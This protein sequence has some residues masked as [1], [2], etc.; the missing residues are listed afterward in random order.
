MFA[1]S[2]GGGS[3]QWGYTVVV[4]S[5]GASGHS[6]IRCLCVESREGMERREGAVPTPAIFWAYLSLT[7]HDIALSFMYPT[8]LDCMRSTLVFIEN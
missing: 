2:S 7:C 3:F 8:R 1:G 6:H 4:P 5:S